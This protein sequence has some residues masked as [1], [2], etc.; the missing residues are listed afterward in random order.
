MKLIFFGRPGSGKGTYASRIAP[1]LGIV[2]VATGDMYRAEVAAGTELGRLAKKYMEKG[3]LV[4]DDVTIKMF[5]E[6]IE[7]SDA[8]KGFILDGFPRTIEQMKALEKITNIDLV[9]NF[10]IAEDIIIEK[11]LARRICEKCGNI[12]NIANI[13]RGNIVMPPLLPKKEGICDKCGGRIVQRK[14][15][16][17]ETIKDRQDTYIRQSMPL[18]EYY[19]KKKMVTDVKVIGGPEQMVPI[20]IDAI[21]KRV[22]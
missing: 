4:P 10:D 12:Y 18:L 17:Y 22:K 11:A 15:D 19:R 1:V 16:N 8:K 9:I 3:E 21:K 14:D 7:K 2:H 6:R 13:K 5:K 20:I